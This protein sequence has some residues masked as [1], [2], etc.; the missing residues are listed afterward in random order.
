[1]WTRESV[2]FNSQ[3]NTLFV[4][5]YE[6]NQKL[7]FLEIRTSYVVWGGR[8]RLLLRYRDGENVCLCADVTGHVDMCV[9]DAGVGGA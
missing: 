7:C 8:G 2:S 6:R 9:G 1:M 5:R 3:M 4:S